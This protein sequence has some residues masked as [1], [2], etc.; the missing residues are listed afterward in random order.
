MLPRSILVKKSHF[1]EIQLECD[2]RTDGQTDGRTD[3]KTDGRK[4]TPFYR[5]ARTKLKKM[6]R[7]FAKR[8]KV[9]TKHK[10]DFTYF[11]LRG[12]GLKS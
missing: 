5:D 4:D 6:G 2:G 11:L 8:K 3:R 7:E 10:Q 1:S 9:K 12:N